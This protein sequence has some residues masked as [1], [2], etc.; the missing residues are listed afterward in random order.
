MG[1]YVVIY[2]SK[3][4]FT[5][6]YASWIAE[7]L[8]CEKYPLENVSMVDLSDYDVIIFGGGVRAGKIGGIKFLNKTRVSLPNKRLVIFATG[9]TPPDENEA[10][11]RVQNM[12]VP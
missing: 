12:N 1:N 10:I 6:K 7:E 11:N 8:N 5:E 9:A 3:T 4:G 2:K